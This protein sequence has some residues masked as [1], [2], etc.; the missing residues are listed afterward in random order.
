MSIDVALVQFL[1]TFSTRFSKLICYFCI[2]LN[3]N[4]FS[5]IQHE[6]RFVLQQSHQKQA[7][8]NHSNGFNANSK[9]VE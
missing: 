6:S 9:R 2:A 8:G 7:K 3:M 4:L 5:D 1:L